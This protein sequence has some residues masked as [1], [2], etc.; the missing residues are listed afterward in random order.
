MDKLKTLSAKPKFIKR[1]YD[2]KE[3]QY[4]A[5]VL[6][7]PNIK[8]DYG[9]QII[10][11]FKTRVEA[12]KASNEPN[13]KKVKF[14]A[15]DSFEI[16]DRAVAINDIEIGFSDGGRS[17]RITIPQG[18]DFKVEDTYADGDTG[19]LVILHNGDNL[20]VEAYKFRKARE[21]KSG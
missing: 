9:D 17:P 20:K 7:D 4:G 18:T 2:I 8:G 11:Y 16:G 19:M 3:G 14:P 15:E 12:E 6:F 21:K 5:Y 10:G 13:Y 1:A